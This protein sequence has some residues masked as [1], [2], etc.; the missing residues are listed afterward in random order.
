MG[1][2]MP[3]NE[4]ILI[5][6]DELGLRSFYEAFFHLRG[7]DV[8]CASSVREAK[9]YLHKFNV[10]LVVLDLLM[11]FENGEALYDYLVVNYP[12]VWIIV[13]S[14]EPTESI[15]DKVAANTKASLHLK[16]LNISEIYEIAVERVHLLKS[17]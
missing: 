3:N 8:I 9:G 6:E 7:C 17:A 15:K 4:T 12:D 11:P 16:P 1:E 2:K 13:A 14:G 10:A 5:V